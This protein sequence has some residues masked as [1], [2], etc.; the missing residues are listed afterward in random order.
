MI[1]NLLFVFLIFT[2]LS[3]IAQDVESK[4][5]WSYSYDQAN[6]VLIFEAKISE[7]WHLYSQF[8]D[9][10]VGPVPTFFTFNR[11]KGGRLIGKTTE[12]APIKIYDP[13]FDG[14]VIY[15]ENEVIFKQKISTRK[16]TEISGAITYMV[17][18]E[19]MC[20]PP[21]DERF[22]IKINK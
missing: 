16:K 22:T 13:N 5:L 14:E 4:V 21:V 7:G 2:S 6:D 11:L 10:E 9:P 1:K 18:N 17:C 15:F 12:P 8:V 3:T 19:T 20:L